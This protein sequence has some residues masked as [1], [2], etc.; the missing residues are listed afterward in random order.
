M[1]KIIELKNYKILNTEDKNA[2]I[3]AVTFPVGRSRMAFTHEGQSV[4]TQR[5]AI[6]R[7]DGSEGP[8]ILG[9]TSPEY[10]LIPHADALQAAFEGMDRVG[11]PFALK[12]VSLDRNGAKMLAQFQVMKPYQITPGNSGDVLYP[13]LTLVNSYDGLNALTLDLESIRL[14]CLNLAKSAVKDISQRF[15]HVGGAD[16]EGLLKTAQLA[17]ENFDTKLVPFYRQLAQVEVSKELAVK[18]VAVAVK[19]QVIPANVASFAKHCV[20]SDR[21]DAEGIKRTAWA[22]YN[23]F[24]WATSRRGEELSPLRHREIRNNVSKLFADGGKTLLQRAAE[25]PAEETAKLLEKAA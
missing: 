9:Y 3:E 14:V 18:A 15:L 8:E 23:A 25:M 12:N 19:E 7:L 24:T 13:V 5:D 4:E 11:M 6:F 17:L 22:M 1:S 16:P 21:A 20:D 10:K 2:A